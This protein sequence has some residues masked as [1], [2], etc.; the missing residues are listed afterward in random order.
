MIIN[1]IREQFKDADHANFS[2]SVICGVG[3]LLTFCIGMTGYLLS[4]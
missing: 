1:W 2:I 3:M 4:R